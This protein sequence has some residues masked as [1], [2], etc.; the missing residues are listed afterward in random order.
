[1]KEINE[2]IFKN[3]YLQLYKNIKKGNILITAYYDKYHNKFFSILDLDLMENK[4][5]IEDMEKDPD[6]SFSIKRLN[7]GYDD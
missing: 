3:T 4:Y 5:Y 7:Y 1:M 2:Q 6:D